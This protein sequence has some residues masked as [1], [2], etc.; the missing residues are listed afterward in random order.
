MTVRLA[1][2]DDYQSLA[3]RLADW[4]LVR[5]R[6]EIKVFTRHLGEDAA[7]EQLRD[8][9]IVCLLR[10]RMAFPRALIERLPRLKFI[11]TTGASTRT[12]DLSAA[13]ERGIMVSRTV[14]RGSGGLATAELA[15]G[16]ILALVRHIP[17]EAT[18]MR[19]GGWQTTI[20]TALGGRTLGVLGLGRLGRSMV[21]IAKAFG[22]NVIAWSQNMTPAA[23]TEAGALY[24]SKDELFAR[25]DVVSLHLVLSERTRH[26]VGE[27]ELSRMRPDAYLVNTARGPLVD[28]AALLR[29]LRDSSIAGAA[30]DTFDI[31]PLPEDDPLRQLD[32]VIL[33]PHLGYTVRELL[34]PFY[35]DTVENVL[36][37]L[38]GM[39]LRTVTAD[40]R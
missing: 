3:L 21:P 1:I 5:T 17:Q 36:A 15:W 26:I 31:E 40:A 2:L 11:A 27:A 18:R 6:C 4:T 38:D 13:S 25:S 37:F 24:V 35:E 32:N 16:L 19:Q 33:T 9:D 12:L 20:G 23:A 39:P 10:E 34:Q 30:L 22:M 28:K 8:Y 14:R 7:A 29:A